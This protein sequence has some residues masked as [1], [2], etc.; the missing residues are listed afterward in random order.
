MYIVFIWSII[1]V[2]FKWLIIMFWFV[3]FYFN[4]SFVIG[5][6][7]IFVIWIKCLC[8]EKV[9]KEVVINSLV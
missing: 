9:N 1:F 5:V 7:E 2:F 4:E 3:I 8:K 6:I